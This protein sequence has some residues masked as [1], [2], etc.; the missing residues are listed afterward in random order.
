MLDDA[1]R[2]L[3]DHAD[4]LVREACGLAGL[5]VAIIAALLLPVLA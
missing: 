4:I 3:R 2:M 1:R 5:C